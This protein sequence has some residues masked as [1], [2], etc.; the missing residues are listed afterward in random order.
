LL[1]VGIGALS[2]TA[3][4]LIHVP[5]N[6]HAPKVKKKAKPSKTKATQAAKKPAVKPTK[7]PVAPSPVVK[8][9]PKPPVQTVNRT[10]SSLT[11]NINV[12][13]MGM[14]DFVKKVYGRLSTSYKFDF[15][16]PVTSTITLNNSSIS[17]DDL[18]SKCRA[19]NTVIHNPAQGD[20]T[21]LV[22]LTP[23]Q[24]MQSGGVRLI[25]LGSKVLDESGNYQEAYFLKA[26]KVTLSDVV[27]RFR[28]LGI[29]VMDETQGAQFSNFTV[30]GSLSSILNSLPVQVTGLEQVETPLTGF[31]WTLKL[32]PQVDALWSLRFVGV[33][34]P[35]T[36]TTNI[37]STDYYSSVLAG[38][39]AATKKPSAQTPAGDPSDPTTP[40]T[41]PP[42]ASTGNV[43]GPSSALTAPV[44]I[45]VNGAAPSPNPT[46]GGSSA[47][48]KTKYL[49]PTNLGAAKYDESSA[50][51]LARLLNA[52]TKGQLETGARSNEVWLHGPKHLVDWAKIL[53][54]RDVDVPYSQ[55]RLDVWTIQVDT[56]TLLH[57]SKDAVAVAQANLDDIRAGF[58]LTQGFSNTITSAIL[59]V[60]ANHL[61]GPILT[62]SQDAYPA[63]NT[64]SRASL[65][66]AMTYCGF[67]VRPARPLTLA[68]A[69]V[70]LGVAQNKTSTTVQAC[71]RSA[72][73]GQGT[74]YLHSVVQELGYVQKNGTTDERKSATRLI[75]LANAITRRF[76]LHCASQLPTPPIPG[77]PDQGKTVDSETASTDKELQDFAKVNSTSIPNQ[78]TPM[79][80]LPNFVGQFGPESADATK[81]GLYDFFRLWAYT[82]APASV[83]FCFGNSRTDLDPGTELATAA[84]GTDTMLKAA[85]D[86]LRDDVED[87]TT[88]PL[89]EWVRE[90]IQAKG[91]AS[92]I[93]LVGK[94]T[95]TA[96]SGSEATLQGAAIASDSW[97]KPAQ[98][99]LSDL[100]SKALS[101]GVTG[102]L[103]QNITPLDAVALQSLL[104]P[105]TNTSTTVAPGISIDVTP[106]VLKDGGSARL[107]ITIDE[108]MN[109]TG[110]AAANPTATASGGSLLI[111]K[112][113]GDLAAALDPP[114][115]SGS[116]TSAGSLDYIPSHQ[117][118]TD[119]AVEASDLFE[120]SSF[121]MEHTTL[122]NPSWSVAV[123]DTLPVIGK[124][125]SG[126]R[127]KITKHQE[128]MMVV[129]V[130]IL[131]KTLDLASGYIGR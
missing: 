77:S 127:V 102:S 99:T 4:A 5:A 106:Y 9:P 62:N 63:D 93:N 119:V 67:D 53:L 11:F 37:F 52:M 18:I 76:L 38:Y 30:D 59:D 13:N 104:A 8:L 87:V 10:G 31:P 83:R 26:D 17:L 92:G 65:A 23:D 126:P 96:S 61:G 89:T 123:L 130:S 47:D 84:Y 28:E 2:L 78:P 118:K 116:S 55:V 1:L 14:Q 66:E 57:K 54:A 24:P 111:G 56:S 98:L 15:S 112:V 64:Y 34:K 73:A 91:N 68:E 100:Q 46:G 22:C 44:A 95:V 114:T 75:N 21:V 80:V 32:E 86:A 43:N 45:T 69:L 48:P 51:A 27:A 12:T 94:A 49:T 36:T 131:P 103:L 74:K 81:N 70:F 108:T 97:Q 50:V 109:D 122:G 125:F 42:S 41:A 19:L 40:T 110:S 58:K 124:L 117:M 85:M 35:T 115:K 107:D 88:V 128:S 33:N 3:D 121:S 29:P 6:P 113:F 101:I 105:P 60:A 120:I 16:E 72:I 20:Y 79:D 7:P 90:D 129:Y 71:L 82:S 39:T 25:D